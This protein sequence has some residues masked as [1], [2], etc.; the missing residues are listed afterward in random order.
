[1]SPETDRVQTNHTTFRPNHETPSSGSGYDVEYHVDEAEHRLWKING[2]ITP[3]YKSA[4]EQVW[5][6]ENWALPCP[7]I[8]I[9]LHLLRTD[10]LLTYNGFG[11]PLIVVP[12][13]DHTRTDC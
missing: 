6:W 4:K 8:T 1:M 5:V 10:G 2:L 11:F 7:R 9:Q 3:P 12:L 13:S